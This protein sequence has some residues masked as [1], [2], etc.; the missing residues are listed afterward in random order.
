MDDPA[1][2][3]G[4]T[5]RE[6]WETVIER[7]V[8]DVNCH[9]GPPAGT[10]GGSPL[11]D[12]LGEARSHGVRLALAHHLTAVWADP[13]TGNR[14]ALDAAADPANRL[15]AVAVVAPDRTFGGR[16]RIGEAARAGAVA[17]RLERVGWAPEPSLALEELLAD[18]AAAGLPLL[19]Q[20]GGPAAGQGFGAATMIGR[21]TSGLG[22][23]VVLLGAHYTHI[24]DDLAAVRRYSH[25]YLE[26]SSLA[27]FRAIETAVRAIGHERLM[28]GSGAPRRAIQSP[29]NAVLLARID[30]D[31][32]RAILAENAVRVF[33]LPAGAVDVRPPTI[34]DRA[35]DV[36]AHFGPLAFDVP[37]V[38][39]ERLLAELTEVGT[40]ALTGS[41]TIG[42]FADPA[43]GNAAM[44]E[45]VGLD[46]GQR[47]Y[48]VADPNDLDLTA[49]QIRRFGE[50]P[51][52][53]G[54]KIHSEWSGVPTASR[55]MRDLFT[56]LSDFGRPVKIHNAGPDWEAALRDIARSHPMLPIIIAHGGPG[57]PTAAGAQVAADCERV[58]V[59]M[60]S[61]FADLPAVR[62]AARVAGPE[63]LLYGTDVP[64]IEPA[65]VQG[66][67]QDAE[68]PPEELDRIF[69]TNAAVLFEGQAETTHG[70]GRRAPEGRPG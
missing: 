40:L 70:A 10:A 48:L 21:L 17:F 57:T 51:G 2:D 4:V 41:S 18:V 60:S 15:R 36:H 68:L 32:R 54:V 25:L 27:H 20:L 62:A 28:F 69:W 61:S 31:A 33:D 59:E 38:A 14:A 12:L 50:R 42:I 7:G 11:T 65:F 66:T 47:G 58:F 63:R 46:G 67:Y 44:V 55:A 5:A 22:V 8:I 34:P 24:V 16:A 56:L 29:L 3:E 64:L 37:A 39:A 52:V 13:D 35:W 30:D 53:V 19:V 49:D 6:P 23:P 1:D 45:A 26:T 43:A 9:F